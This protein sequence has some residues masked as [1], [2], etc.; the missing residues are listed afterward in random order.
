MASHLRANAVA[1][2]PLLASFQLHKDYPREIRTR[3][4]SSA[5]DQPQ[6]LSHVEHCALFLEQPDTYSGD[7]ATFVWIHYLPV[8]GIPSP[9]LPQM[10]GN[11][12]ASA[13][14]V[15]RCFSTPFSLAKP[16]IMIPLIHLLSADFSL[17]LQNHFEGTKL[18]DQRMNWASGGHLRPFIA[19]DA[20]DGYGGCPKVAEGNGLTTSV[21]ATVGCSHRR[22]G[23]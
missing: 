1:L 17:S 10:Q 7:I 14:S 4:G 5:A 11:W 22:N 3:V 23:M 12:Q 6:D 2:A 16:K 9:F 15:A 18:K 8:F 13:H 19:V 20:T 21:A